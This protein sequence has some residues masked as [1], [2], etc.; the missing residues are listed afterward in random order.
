MRVGIW[1]SWHIS[2][3]PS[4]RWLA[5]FAEHF[6]AVNLYYVYSSTEGTDRSRTSV[7]PAVRVSV[8]RNAMIIIRF[9]KIRLQR[10][11]RATCAYLS[12]HNSNSDCTNDG[13]RGVEKSRW[14]RNGASTPRLSLA[15]R[16]GVT[17]VQSPISNRH[18]GF[19]HQK[20]WQRRP[21]N[22]Y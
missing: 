12:G 20:L 14:T 19:Y 13:Y 21:V 1:H 18:T 9:D 2:L 3:L 7:P 11:G 4:L 6:I 22:S 8:Q 17:R 5:N 10:R 16:T 15:D